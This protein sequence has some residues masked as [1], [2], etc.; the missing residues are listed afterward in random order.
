MSRVKKFSVRPGIT[1]FLHFRFS[2]PSHLCW[3]DGEQNYPWRKKEASR[4]EKA[5][6]NCIPFLRNESDFVHFAQVLAE[7]HNIRTKRIRVMGDIP[8]AE[9]RVIAIQFIS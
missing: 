7:M 2:E 9:N 5:E 8:T 3:S 4:P 6:I 1:L